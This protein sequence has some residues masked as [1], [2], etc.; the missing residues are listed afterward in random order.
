[1]DTKN[2]SNIHAK[3]PR[4]LTPVITVTFVSDE[5]AQRKANYA[6]DQLARWIVADLMK[7]EEEAVATK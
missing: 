2:V 5:E 6:L 3:K 1:M 7:A 4:K